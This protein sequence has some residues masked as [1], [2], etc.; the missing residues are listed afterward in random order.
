MARRSLTTKKKKR[1]HLLGA[2]ASS[3]CV[4]SPDHSRASIAGRHHRRTIHRV[5]K[6][7]AGSSSWGLRA[8]S[9]LRNLRKKLRKQQKWQVRKSTAWVTHQQPRKNGNAASGGFSRGPKSSEMFVATVPTSN[10][11]V[12]LLALTRFQVPGR[13]PDRLS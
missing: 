9:V 11:A 12:H 2:R 5:P 8:P 10:R 6:P 3:A 7:S 13:S 1:G 4:F